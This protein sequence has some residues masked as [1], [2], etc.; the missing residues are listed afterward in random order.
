M[1]ITTPSPA[2]T[3]AMDELDRALEICLRGPAADVA[4]ARCQEQ[5]KA[6]E[7]VLPNVAPLVLDFGLGDFDRVGLIESWVANEQAAGYCGKFLFVFAGQEC[8]AH[9]HRIK[10]ETFFIVK[11]QATITADGQT[12][13]Y[14]PGG[15]LPVAPGVVHSFRGVTA[16]LLLEVSKPCEVADNYFMD[17]RIPI[18]GN[19]R[20]TT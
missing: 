4:L 14:G 6:W 8:P 2:R 18:G 13:E 12:R 1:N 9:A 16:C 17:T 3:H 20:P 7:F 10:H 15:V 11:G 5:L 19:F